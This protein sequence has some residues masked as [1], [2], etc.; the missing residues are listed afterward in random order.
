ML[1]S[2]HIG[3]V[4]RRTRPT[5]D[6]LRRSSD[7]VISAEGQKAAA[8]AAGSAPISDAQRHQVAEVVD[9]IKG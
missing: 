5:A 2:Y 1:V 4:R 6:L 7:Y 8:K 3:C 9:A